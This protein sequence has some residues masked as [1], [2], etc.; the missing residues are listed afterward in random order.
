MQYS[1]INEPIWIQAIVLFISQIG[2]IYARTLNVYYN[3]KLNRLGV[4]L[5]G[6]VVHIFWLITIAVGATAIVKGNYVLVLFS[7]S[8]GL[9]GADWALRNRIKSNND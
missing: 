2:F 4:F 6:F 8:G 9:L 1:I 5:T 7:L 3:S